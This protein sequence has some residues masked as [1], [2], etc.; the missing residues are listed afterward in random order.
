M[1]NLAEIPAGIAIPVLIALLIEAALYLTL[2][3]P[4]LRFRIPPPLL[5]LTGMIPYLVYSVPCRV[6]DP[7]SLA[8]IAIGSLLAVYW[9][10][11]LPPGRATDFAF[12]LV[13]AAPILFK[14]P[15][16]LYGRP[17]PEAR[18]EILGHLLWIRLGILSVLRDR[19]PDGIGFGFWPRADDWKVG[20]F[21]FALFAPAA[22]VLAFLLHFAEFRPPQ[23]PL[24]LTALS[25]AG[26]FFGVL[27]VVALSEEFF[28][29]GLLEQWLHEWTGSRGAALVAASL[30]FG[31]AHLG[32]RQFPN[33]R[34][35]ALA[36]CAGVFYGLAFLRG[37]GIRAAMVT[38]ALVVT[39]WRILFR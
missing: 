29:R 35:A 39:T 21:F 10:R 28:F 27:W 30:L 2:A 8:A 19:R 11:L 14:V 4:G 32:Y 7:T 5:V 15:A 16:I 9:F 33:W 24:W 17:H 26:T 38:H 20:A 22:T 12:I 13:M 31:A 34:F 36:A 25:I 37:R 6:F 1:H 3:F 18:V 23:T